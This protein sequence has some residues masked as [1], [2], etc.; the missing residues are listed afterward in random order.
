MNSPHMLKGPELKPAS[1]GKAKQLIIF[2]HGVG[3]DGNDLIGLAYEMAEKLPDAHFISPNAPEQFDMAPF[4]FQ[5]FSLKEY[6]QSDMRLAFEQ[7]GRF[8]GAQHAAP[9][10]QH[11][12]DER[13]KQ[14]GLKDKDLV[15]IG[16][17]QGTM[18]ALHIGL[19][20]KHPPAAI[21]GFSGALLGTDFLHEEITCRPPV[22]LIHGEEDPVVPFYLMER[23]KKSLE[24]EG[25]T[26][27]IHAR[28]MLAHG[29]DQE[30]IDIALNFIEK[31]LQPA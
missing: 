1:G 15:L 4:G 5:W 11:F 27:E 20:R 19:R 13:L 3:A 30:G 31:H 24:K 29:I 2:L 17:S 18:M 26:A 12:I 28:P 21:V 25:V 6:A 16:F 23:A 14:H 9:I 8:K 22:C 10:L 7:A